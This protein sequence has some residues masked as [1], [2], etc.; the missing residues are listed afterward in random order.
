MTSE[1]LTKFTLSG[2]WYKSCSVDLLDGTIDMQI[3]RKKF[4]AAT[5]QVPAWHC[6]W[7][8]GY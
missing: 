2:K 7:D 8:G 1:I 6:I 3:Q 4:W 5:S